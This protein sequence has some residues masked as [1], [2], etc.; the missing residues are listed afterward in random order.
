MIH[1]QEQNGPLPYFPNLVPCGI[2][3]FSEMA[4]KLKRKSFNNVL[5]IQKNLQH[6]FNGTMKCFSMQ[7]EFFSV[8]LD[9]LNLVHCEKVASIINTD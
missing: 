8:L 1:G 3:L 9:L 2:F 5:E 7:A 4:L 6:M